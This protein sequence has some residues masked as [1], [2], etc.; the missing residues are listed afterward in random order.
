MRR[1]RD[2]YVRSFA[3]DRMSVQ[4]QISV[5]TTAPKAHPVRLASFTAAPIAGLQ[6]SASASTVTP[7]LRK[8]AMPSFPLATSEYN[9]SSVFQSFVRQR[10]STFGHKTDQSCCNSQQRHVGMPTWHRLH[11]ADTPARCMTATVHPF[12]RCGLERVPASGSF[13]RNSFVNADRRRITDI[14]RTPRVHRR[15]TRLR[16]A[17]SIGLP[18]STSVSS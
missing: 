12:K 6:P 10:A 18:D 16:R 2:H 14:A 7:S 17:G 15:G 13:E 11:R 8:P 5:T 4:F 3:N 1:I 9:S